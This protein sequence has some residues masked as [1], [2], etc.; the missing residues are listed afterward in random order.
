MRNVFKTFNFYALVLVKA[1]AKAMVLAIA[2][3]P[4]D[5]CIELKRFREVAWQRN[6]GRLKE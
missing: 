3:H 5:K 6:E 2:R 1:I 4:L